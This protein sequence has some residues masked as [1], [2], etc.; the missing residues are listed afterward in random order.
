[1]LILSKDKVWGSYERVST[2]TK[3]CRIS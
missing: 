2:V 1:M 3:T